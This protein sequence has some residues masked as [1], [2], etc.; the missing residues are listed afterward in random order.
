MEWR[1]NIKFCNI[2]SKFVLFLGY[3]D[4][5][6]T[7]ELNFYSWVRFVS[8]AL[9]FHCDIV[10]V[11]FF[12]NSKLKHFEIV[13]QVQIRLL[14]L[15]QLIAY[16]WKIH[17]QCSQRLFRLDYICMFIRF[18]VFITMFN[19]THVEMDIVTHFIMGVEGLP[20]AVVLGR[21]TM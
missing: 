1:T 20:I 5:H 10:L 19:T 3:T 13:T 16:T 7:H 15:A 11:S 2:F 9:C 12:F 4:T 6:Y 17:V 18:I 14:V 8:P 21:R